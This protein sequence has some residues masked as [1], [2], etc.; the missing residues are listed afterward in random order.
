[1]ALRTSTSTLKAP[2]RDDPLGLTEIGPLEVPDL[3]NLDFQVGPVHELP[4]PMLSGDCTNDTCTG[5]CLSC[6]CSKG[7]DDG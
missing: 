2:E 7:C 3:F 4:G 5:T 1:M 6:G